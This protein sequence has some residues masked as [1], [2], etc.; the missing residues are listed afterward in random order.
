VTPL[1]LWKPAMRLGSRPPFDRQPAQLIG[2]VEADPARTG[3]GGI[4]AENV[5]GV[6]VAKDWIDVHPLAGSARRIEMKTAL[7]KRFAQAAAHLEISEYGISDDIRP[8]CWR[9]RRVGV[10]EGA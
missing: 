6:D 9:W 5:I 4:M 1:D 10:V 3:T 7:L 2:A 8:L